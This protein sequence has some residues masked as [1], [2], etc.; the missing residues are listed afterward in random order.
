MN[1]MLKKDG[2]ESGPFTKEEIS[3]MLSDGRITKT[4]LAFAEGFSNW[5]PVV[6]V[7]APRAA[8]SPAN[9]FPAA[10]AKPNE[11]LAE[12]VSQNRSFNWK[13]VIPLKEIFQDKPWD[14]LWVRWALWFVGSLCLV[15]RLV[16]ASTL[17]SSTGMFL[18]ALD[19]CL[20]WA[21]ALFFIIKPEKIQTSTV[22]KLVMPS[23]MLTL[24]F[25]LFA[26]QSHFMERLLQ[27]KTDYSMFKRVG[28]FLVTGLIQQLIFVA[29]FFVVYGKLKQKDSAASITF[30]G[31]VA[32]MLTSL[33][34][35]LLMLLALKRNGYSYYSTSGFD[36]T[37]LF[38]LLALP[39]LAGILG[40]ITGS[41][42]AAGQRE[43]MAFW[44]WMS[45]AVILPVVLSTLYL[46]SSS[47]VFG[48]LVVVVAIL[49]LNARLKIDNQI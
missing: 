18:V 9:S 21:I 8:H 42:M 7:L 14:L 15:E 37:Q 34:P 25:I 47:A 28:A 3:A 45:A 22:F 24:L 49:T 43:E 44:G 48:V 27:A 5:L 12:F 11:A 38:G 40:A 1:I 13:N 20:A 30:Y 36:S 10:R 23:A 19:W 2:Q 32:G 46:S 41:L 31:L 29:P 6:A 17:S 39:V 33:M 16:S 35:W 26:S 4:H